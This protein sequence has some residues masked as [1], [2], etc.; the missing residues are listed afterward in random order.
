[1]LAGDLACYGTVY[2]VCQPVFA[3]YGFQL[4]HIGEIFMQ[5]RQFVFRHFIMTF[6]GLVH[7][8]SFRRRTEHL[9]Y[10]KIERTY[11]V[12][13]LESEAVVAGSFTDYVHRSPFAFGHLAYVLD[14]FFLNQ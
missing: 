5:L 1:M 12:G 11:T 7:H 9:F 3:G 10:G 14:S 2:L 8:V 4:E 6:Y 13:L